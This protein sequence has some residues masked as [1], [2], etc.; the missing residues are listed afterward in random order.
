MFINQAITVNGTAIDHLK[1]IK[2]FLIN[3]TIAPFTLVDEELG[4]GDVVNY[5]KLK[6]NKLYI[7]VS[8]SDKYSSSSYGYCFNVVI[9]DENETLFSSDANRSIYTCD[10]DTGKYAS[11]VVERT[12]NIFLTSNETENAIALGI[13]SYSSN[14]KNM[15]TKNVADWLVLYYES[16]NCFLSCHTL[17]SNYQHYRKYI[18]NGQTVSLR[19]L[20]LVPQDISKLVVVDKVELFVTS[21]NEHIEFLSSLISV[22]GATEGN[23]Y[24]I[25]SKTYLCIQN[26]I[27]LPI[28]EKTEYTPTTETTESEV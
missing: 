20:V 11:W 24:T 13:F 19:E 23:C 6:R 2:D 27:C 14:L 8:L 12:I 5:I 1:A 3:N 4:G 21:T 9:F 26:R 16:K 22:G 17:N 18:L 15:F 7:Q 28:G 25:N 10:R